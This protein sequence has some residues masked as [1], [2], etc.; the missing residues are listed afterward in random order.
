MNYTLLSGGV[1]EESSN[2]QLARYTYL[3]LNSKPD[4]SVDLFDNLVEG[5]PFVS[6]KDDLLPEILISAR[7]SLI[8][9]DKVI[10]FSPIFNG[11]Y[12]ASLKNALDWLSLSFDS[13]KYNELYKDKKIAIMSSVLGKGG[14][15]LDAR[16][17]LGHQLIKYGFHLYGESYLFTNAEE[18]MHK[19]DDK[20]SVGNRELASFLDKFILF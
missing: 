18:K 4:I 2:N 7:G 13:Y 6:E 17:M 1:R 5:V 12:A 3:Y 19:L 16:K 8:N 10:V 20:D 15:S 9:S 11:G 14:N